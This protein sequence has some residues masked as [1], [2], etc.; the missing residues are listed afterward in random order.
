VKKVAEF[1]KH[2]KGHKNQEDRYIAEGL[3]SHTRSFKLSRA[4]AMLTRL[5]VFENGWF[6]HVSKFMKYNTHE[7]TA[8][9]VEC[10]VKD[11]EWFGGGLI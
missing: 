5:G 8:F 11:V 9:V 4:C 6:I 7:L 2:G 3:I 10:I 1:F